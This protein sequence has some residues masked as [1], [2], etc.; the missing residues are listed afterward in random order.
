L[1]FSDIVVTSFFAGQ[2][3]S[4]L[5]GQIFFLTVLLNSF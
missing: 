5:G 2:K 3:T 1:F 4:Y